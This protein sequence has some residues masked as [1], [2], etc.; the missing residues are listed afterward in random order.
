MFSLGNIFKNSKQYN[1]G[2]AKAEAIANK[3]KKY[4]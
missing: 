3:F 1:P 4:H 2:N